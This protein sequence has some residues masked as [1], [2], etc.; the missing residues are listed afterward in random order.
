[1]Q[2]LSLTIGWLVGIVFNVPNM[3]CTG[4]HSWKNASNSVQQLTTIQH[5]TL[6]PSATSQ[7]TSPVDGL[8]V[9]NVL[10]S[11]ASTHSLLM[12]IWT[13]H[14]TEHIVPVSK[15]EITKSKQPCNGHH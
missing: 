2:S 6:L 8:I 14:Q 15:T 13:N 1:M 11:T 9:E 3:Y 5:D 10:P 7:I 12:K 4:M